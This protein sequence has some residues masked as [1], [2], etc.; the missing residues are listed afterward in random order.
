MPLVSDRIT[1]T[2]SS[3]REGVYIIKKIKSYI[4]LLSILIERK[5]TPNR[6]EYTKPVVMK[7]R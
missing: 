7:Y 1:P 4:I 5:S 2:S 3:H 6:H